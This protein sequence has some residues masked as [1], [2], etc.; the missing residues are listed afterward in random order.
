V[1]IELDFARRRFAVSFD[2]DVR[3]R[4][5]AGAVLSGAFALR[6]HWILTGATLRV[7]GAQRAS[8]SENPVSHTA[9]PVPP[10]AQ[11]AERAKEEAGRAASGASVGRSWNE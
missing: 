6:G 1:E 4:L 9:S 5:P 8:L 11:R 7:T 2:D 10:G 3:A